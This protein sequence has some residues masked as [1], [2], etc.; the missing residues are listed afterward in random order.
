MAPDHPVVR[1]CEDTASRCAMPS[2]EKYSPETRCTLA[3]FSAVD[4]GAYRSHALLSTRRR[5]RGVAA[6]RLNIGNIG[7]GNRGGGE[8]TTKSWPAWHRQ[9]SQQDGVQHRKRGRVR[10]D[11]Q[12][13][14][15]TTTSVN[16]GALR[17]V[18][19]AK[20][21]PDAARMNGRPPR[22]R[23]PSPAARRRIPA[24]GADARRRR[25]SR[26]ARAPREQIQ[27]RL[28]RRSAQSDDGLQRTRAAA[29]GAFETRYCPSERHALKGV[30]YT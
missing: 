20:E 6:R 8:E 18:R 1:R 30:V 17:K 19:M 13:Q 3:A 9:R 16:P 25:T 2:A 14:V 7:A 24:R 26:L 21:D 29:T 5:R 22:D 11:A 12:R 23:S 15:T 10:A 4:D 27:M 28:I